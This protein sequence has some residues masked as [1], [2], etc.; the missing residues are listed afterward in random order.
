MAKKKEVVVPL[1][2]LAFT[3]DEITTLKRMVFMAESMIYHY[4]M[5]TCRG[6]VERVHASIVETKDLE[7]NGPKENTAYVKAMKSYDKKYSIQ[8]HIELE[9][10]EEEEEL[11]EL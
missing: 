3:G 2:M 10:T 8:F 1:A 9:K 11:D 5:E 4:Y 6:S 7:A